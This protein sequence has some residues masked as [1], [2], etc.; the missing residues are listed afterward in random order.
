MGAPGRSGLAIRGGGAGDCSVGRKGKPVLVQMERGRKKRVEDL[1]DLLGGLKL[2]EE[3]R[4]AVKGVWQAERRE[5]GR[6]PQA[7]GK[8]FS[9]KSGYADGL[10]QTVGRIWCPREGI[11]CKE[12]GNNS[13]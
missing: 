2:S 5:T 12:L 1:E 10:A 13:G 9:S 6:P 11:R 4:M 3:E 7:V 8:L